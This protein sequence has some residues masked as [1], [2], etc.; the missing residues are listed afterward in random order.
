VLY[1]G[2]KCGAS[3]PDH[4]HFQAGDRSFLPIDAEYAAVT[5]GNA[6]RL[7]ESGSLRACGVENYLRRFISFESADAGLL[8]RAFRELYEVLHDSAPG[9]EEPM[10]NILGVYRD[11]QWRIIVFPRARHRPSF[12]FKE[13]EEKLLISPAAVELGGI[14]TT[15]REQDFEK[16]TRENIVDMYNEICVSAER[17]AAIKSRLARKL[18]VLAG[19]PARP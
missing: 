6:C 2:P 13:G 3:A 8:L 19:S 16:V 18:V 12:Y 7:F 5:E 17:F 4:L 11:E 9:S 1:N 14:C 15:P 10:L